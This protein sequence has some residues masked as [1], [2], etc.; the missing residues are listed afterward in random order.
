MSYNPYKSLII[1]V[2][3]SNHLTIAFFLCDYN[4]LAV[5]EH[6]LCCIRQ[7]VW[8]CRLPKRHSITSQQA[9]SLLSNQHIY[10]TTHT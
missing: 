1:D 3:D 9:A 2:I 5:M 7:A 10:N 4:N 6:A 8:F